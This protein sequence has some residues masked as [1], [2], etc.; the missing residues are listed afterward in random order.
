MKRRHQSDESQSEIHTPHRR[1]VWTTQEDSLLVTLMK[2]HGGKKWRQVADTLATEACNGAQKKTPKQCRERWYTRLDP[3]IVDAPWSP[4]E[5]FVLFKEH[6]VL[7]NRWAEIAVKLPGRTS[8]AIKNY[9]FCKV[10]KLARNIRNKTC[11]INEG[12]SKDYIFQVAYMLSHLY[13]R[14][15]NPQSEEVKMGG[16]KYIADMLS[17]D[18]LGCRCFEEYVRFFLSNLD[19]EIVQQTLAEYPELRLFLAPQ[20]KQT[21]SHDF[22]KKG[23]VVEWI[24]SCPTRTVWCKPLEIYSTDDLAPG[25]VNLIKAPKN[26]LALPTIDF[27]KRTSTRSGSDI[28]PIF[29]FSVYNGLIERRRGRDEWIERDGDCKSAK[30]LRGGT[31]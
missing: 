20:T 30:E 3:K 8:N 15:I 13:T 19:A 9:F 2:V 14:Y 18:S 4:E 7:G 1:C 5:Q 21:S 12:K 27:A 11:E 22:S 26:C 16:D 17:K 6:K 24:S 25:R 29:D 10:R 31:E 28:A 23:N